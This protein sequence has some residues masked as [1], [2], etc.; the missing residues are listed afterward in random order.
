MEST[1]N[2][3]LYSKNDL[4]DFCITSN[5]EQGVGLGHTYNQHF[6]INSL[7]LLCMRTS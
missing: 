7:F 3:D 4:V 2:C 1:P 6:E 5:K